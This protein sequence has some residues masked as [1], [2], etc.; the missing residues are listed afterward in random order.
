MPG[1]AEPTIRYG[2]MNVAENTTNVDVAA[3]H[4]EIRLSGLQSATEYVFELEVDGTT[5]PGS[6]VTAPVAPSRM[7]RSA[8][9]R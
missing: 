2:I 4:H 3:T 7:L 5:Y 8:S 6:F 9:S 1:R